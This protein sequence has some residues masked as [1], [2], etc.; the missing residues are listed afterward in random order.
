MGFGSCCGGFT[1]TSC[2]R[3]GVV[4]VIILLLF[5]FGRDDHC[6]VDC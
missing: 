4:I 1:N 6:F 2:G 3:V 5:F